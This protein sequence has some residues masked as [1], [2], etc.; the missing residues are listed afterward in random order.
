MTFAINAISRTALLIAVLGYTERCAIAQPPITALAISSSGQQYITGSQAGISIHNIGDQALLRSVDTQLEQ[1]HDLCLSSDGAYLIAAGGS[2]AE[3]GT[4]EFYSW[5]QAERIRSLSLSEDLIY[6]IQTTSDGKFLVAS[7]HENRCWLVSM[8]GKVRVSYANHSRPVLATTPMPANTSFLSGGTD[9]TIQLWSAAGERIRTLSN[10]TG[11]VTDMAVQ[12]SPETNL[13]HLIS[14]SEDRSVRLW[15]PEIG[16]M[17][18]FVRLESIPRRVIWLSDSRLVVACDDGTIS[19]I[20]SLEMKILWTHQ[21]QIKP[22]Y[23]LARFRDSVMVAGVGGV[24]S[25]K[26]LGES[27]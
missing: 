11:S 16:R 2:P 21:S 5:P 6:R 14:T 23:E 25:V 13:V 17:V 9:Q 22:I 1:V 4:I 10:H 19:I 27:E 3:Q 12:V 20:D 15:Q 8:D 7:G 26:L 24:E 18:R